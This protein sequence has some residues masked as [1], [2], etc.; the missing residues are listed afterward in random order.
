M[1][2]YAKMYSWHNILDECLPYLTVQGSE[3]LFE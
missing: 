2:S 3:H 1:D